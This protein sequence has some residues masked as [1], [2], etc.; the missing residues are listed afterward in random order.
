MLL[1]AVFTKRLLYNTRVPLQKL[2]GKNDTHAIERKN[3]NS[4]SSVEIT[5][6]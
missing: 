5:P 1:F 3:P 2:G 4:S 6:L